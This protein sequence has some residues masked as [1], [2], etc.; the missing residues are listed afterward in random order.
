MH[1]YIL[2]I[3]VL[4]GEVGSMVASHHQH[5]VNQGMSGHHNKTGS[6]VVTYLEISLRVLPENIGVSTMQAPSLA[7]SADKCQNTRQATLI[8]GNY[9]VIPAL[10][11]SGQ[12]GLCICRIPGM[13]TGEIED[14]GAL[15]TSRI[16][17]NVIL[18]VFIYLQ[19]L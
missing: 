18:Q 2:V 1:H 16:V 12:Q 6:T 15:G 10:D 3:I 7:L 9:S 4:V 17:N 19:W 14:S 8:L 5:T 13:T 11:K